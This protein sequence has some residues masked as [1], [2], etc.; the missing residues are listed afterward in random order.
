MKKQIGM[1]LLLFWIAVPCLPGSS[2][3]VKFKYENLGTLAG[4]QAYQFFDGKQA[5]INDAGQVS[6]ISFAAGGDLHA[7]VKSPGQPMLDL[8]GLIPG[9]GYSYAPCLNNSGVAGGWYND[10]SGFPHAVKWLPQSG[11]SYNYASIGGNYSS[12]RGMNNSGYLAGGGSLN[13]GQV[14]PPVGDPQVLGVLPG[15]TGCVATAINQANT[16]VGYALNASGGFTACSWSPSGSSFSAPS[17]LFG[18]ANGR[19]FAINNPGQAVGYVYQSFVF[20]AVL[21]SPGQLEFQDLGSLYPG[22]SALAYDINDAGQVVG[23]AD[24]LSGTHN[25]FLWTSTAGMQNLNNLVVNLPA[26]VRLERA[27]AINKQG[28]IAGYTANRGAL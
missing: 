5:G 27:M 8:G 22:F 26:G 25:A 17:S 28:Q 24:D 2:E 3:A 19:A 15:H 16:V 20:H 14:W 11:G 23:E 1:A 7:F 6:G 13:S 18:V 4:T 9:S 10:G 21:K 12:V